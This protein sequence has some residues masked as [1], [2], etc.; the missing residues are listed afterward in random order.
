ML[1]PT[2]P[3]RVRVPATSANIGVGF[4]SIGLA[5]ACYNTFTVAW[6]TTDEHQLAPTANSTVTFP[7]LQGEA[8]LG[9]IFFESAQALWHH[10]HGDTS[11]P[12]PP[13]AVTSETH[14]P[15]ARGLGSSAT[16][17]VG[18]LVGLNALMG[19]PCTQAHLLKLAIALEGHPDNVAPALLGG[20][21]LGNLTESYALPWPE[22]WH[23]AV[24]IPDTPIKT[25]DARQALPTDYPRAD[26]ALALRNSALLTH[27]L[28][29]AN[30]TLLQQILQHDVVHEPYRLPLIPQGN[31]IQRTLAGVEGCLGVTVSG[32][33]STLLV[34]YLAE[35]WPALRDTWQTLQAQYPAY[36]SV[37]LTPYPLDTQGAICI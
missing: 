14:I 10:V 33:G 31:E 21:Q 5:L 24:I 27:A 8:C 29:T 35:A 30:A 2:A 12:L 28:H 11:M 23:C 37:E 20:V 36:Q 15:L 1:R 34:V 17:V 19:S 13:L 25:E 32:S 4:D 7:P 6:A 26:V 9:N 16:A 18:A 3:I 22:G